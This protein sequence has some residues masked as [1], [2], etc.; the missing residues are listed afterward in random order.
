[1]SPLFVYLLIPVLEIDFRS[2]TRPRAAL[3]S[4]LVVASLVS[5]AMH[6][7][8]ATQLACWEWN[9]SP[10]DVNVAQER[11]WDWRDA[12]FMRGLR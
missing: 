2:W 4:A 3:A 11:L 12:Q 10:E 8:G 5:F 1:L 7:Q 6:S 9:R